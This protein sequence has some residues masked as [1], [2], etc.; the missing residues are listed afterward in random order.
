MSLLHQGFIKSP[1]VPGVLLTG[2]LYSIR[3]NYTLL[4]FLLRISLHF[5]RLYR[6]TGDFAAALR[7]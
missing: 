7:L 6:Q 4:Y 3:L 1:A 2:V 5:N